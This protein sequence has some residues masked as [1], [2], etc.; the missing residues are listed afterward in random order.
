MKCPVCGGKMRTD[1]EG[2]R[3]VCLNKDCDAIVYWGGE[4]VE[5]GKRI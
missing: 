3:Y 1:A 2:K 4:K 5:D